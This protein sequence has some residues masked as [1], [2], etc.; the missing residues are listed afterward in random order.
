MSPGGSEMEN[1]KK[2]SPNDGDSEVSLEE[3][4]ENLRDRVDK[5]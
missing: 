4:A 3:Q 5:S 1:W 2:V